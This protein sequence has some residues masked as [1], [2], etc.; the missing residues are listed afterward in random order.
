MIFYLAEAFCF[1]MFFKAECREVNSRSEDFR[2][3]QNT[4][5]ANTVD[6]HFHVGIAIWV[7]QISEMRAPSGILSITFNNDG[8]FIQSIS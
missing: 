5:T 3:C 1:C 4:D 6:L 7:S 8:I 2:F